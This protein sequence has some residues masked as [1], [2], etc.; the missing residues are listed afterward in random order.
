M[1]QVHSDVRSVRRNSLQNMM[2]ISTIKEFTLMKLPHLENNKIRD[3]AVY[4]FTNNHLAQGPIPSL[5]RLRC[6]IHILKID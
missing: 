3:Y 4:L 2:L 5:Y 1:K 6:F